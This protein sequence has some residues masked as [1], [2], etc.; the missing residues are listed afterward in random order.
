MTHNYHERRGTGTRSIQES[1]PCR[2]TA[3]VR[4]KG[5]SA[6]G[7]AGKRDREDRDRKTCRGGKRV[8]E[9]YVKGGDKG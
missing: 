3:K 2:G 7:E 6:T 1:R 5:S 4:P 9:G 8:E